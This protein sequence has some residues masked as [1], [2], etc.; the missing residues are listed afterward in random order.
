MSQGIDGAIGDFASLVG[1]ILTL[2][3]LFT[4]M[5]DAEV[6]SLELG[7]KTDEALAR[8]RRE[9][10]LNGILAAVT[11]LLFTTG[12]PLYVRTWAH[13]PTSSDHSIRWGFLIV[14]PLLVPLATWQIAITRR[15]RTAR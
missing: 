9:V 13:F 4:G 2:I 7:T 11:L 1:L 3:T 10:W 14:W 12:L 5:R 6:R 15:A 8:L